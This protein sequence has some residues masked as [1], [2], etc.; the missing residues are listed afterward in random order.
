[1]K[2]NIAYSVYLIVVFFHP[3]EDD[4]E[5]LT[6]L[7]S[8]YEGVCVDNTPAPVFHQKHIGKMDY[9]PCGKNLGIA[10][11]QNVGIRHLLDKEGLII[12]LDQDTRLGLDYPYRIAE[13][14]VKYTSQHIRLGIIGPTVM[15]IKDNREYK[16]AIHAPKIAANGLVA[17]R[18]IISSGACTS[19]SIIK[20]V[21][22]NDSSLFID[23]VDFDWCWRANALGYQCATT[24]NLKIMHQVGRREIW[25]GK[26]LLIISSPSRY[27]YQYRNYLWLMRRG[28]VPL[29]W[30]IATGIKFAAR[31]I[32]FPL[33]IQNGIACWKYMLKGIRYGLSVRK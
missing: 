8:L 22:L 17:K 7:A 16:S 2:S 4:I 13:E 28:Y 15:N 18:E 29:Q 33:I 3:T 26:Y 31:L 24:Q 32:Y 12:F 6:Q 25:I 20:E 11:A 10:E 23:Y 30:K 21:G 27:F 1:M 5:Y 19:I 9:L 14:F